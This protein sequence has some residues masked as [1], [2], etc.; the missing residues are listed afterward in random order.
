MVIKKSFR[1]VLLIFL[2]LL[3]G[4][5]GTIF[6]TSS[7]FSFPSFSKSTSNKEPKIVEDIQPEEYAYGMRIDT[8]QVFEATVMPDEFVS[9]IL[10]RYKVNSQKVHY[11]AEASS[12]IYDFKKFK[13]GNTYKIFTEKNK[14]DTIA[15]FLVYEKNPVEYVVYNLEDTEDVRV[16]E[17]PIEVKTKTIEGVIEGSLWN[18]LIDA[19][20]DPELAVKLSQVYQWTIDFTR[21]NAGDKFKAYY[22]ELFV[23]GKY[24][25]TDS[26]KACSFVHRD[27][28]YFAFYFDQGDEKQAGYY[29]EKGESL[30]RAFLKAPVKYSRISSRYTKRRFHPVQK[31]YKAHLGTDFAA[32]HGTPIYATGA[33]KVIAAS[34][35][36]GNGN[37]VK[38][39]HNKTYTTQYLHMSKRAVSN[40]KFV[41]QGEII[42]YVGSTGL[43]TGPHVCY[44]FWKNGVQV[45]PLALELP[46]GDPIEDDKLAAFEEVKAKY[47]QALTGINPSVIE[48][49]KDEEEI[50]S[51]ENKPLVSSIS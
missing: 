14:E 20:A 1:T 34:Y 11:L 49:E 12:S 26:I 37:Y 2:G 13:A 44:R 9:Q 22:N 16:Y 33:G 18:T 40:G 3:L 41:Q 17:K 15:K 43:A 30:K 21:I 39:K 8:F 6:F 48:E 46:S 51:Q 4:I 19:G 50:K 28:E 45:D 24:Y 25:R 32:P 31:R 36:R 23:D 47:L 29:D 38:V 7:S 10:D 35:T 5:G 42:G 27:K